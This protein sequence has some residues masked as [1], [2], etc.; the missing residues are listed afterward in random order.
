GSDANAAPTAVAPAAPTT[1][2]ATTGAPPAGPPG[3]AAAVDDMS[4]TAPDTTNRDVT[5][6]GPG[7]VSGAPQP[8]MAYGAFHRGFYLTAFDLAIAK[9]ETGDRSAQTLIGLIYEGG[10]GVPRNFKEA[11]S[12]YELSANAGDREAQFLL[13]M[14]YMDGR[15]V[16][17]DLG[18]AAD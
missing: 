6:V 15:G 16:T 3:A 2:T 13:G 14:M 18:K 7:G 4:L 5:P 17:S 9:A 8:D 11:A 12:W 10:Y 1:E